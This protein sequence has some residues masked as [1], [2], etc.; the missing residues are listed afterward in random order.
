LEQALKRPSSYNALKKLLKMKNLYTLMQLDDFASIEEVKKKRNEFMKNIH[1]DKVEG[2]S[3]FHNE[4]AANINLAYETLGNV[5]KKEAYDK[6]LMA[7]QAEREK[8]EILSAVNHVQAQQTAML[9]EENTKLKSNNTVLK[10]LAGI[11][12]FGVLIALFSNNKK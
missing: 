3:P 6:E 1:P 11:L 10:V 8:N 7:N 2:D 12:G 5:A 4:L 9:K